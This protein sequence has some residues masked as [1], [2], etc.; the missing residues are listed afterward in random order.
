MKS[1]YLL[2]SLVAVLFVSAPS[3]AQ[4]GTQP[5]K[6]KDTQPA[7]D[8]KDDHK[9][10]DHKNDKK[11]GEKKDKSDKG[12]KVEV[13]QA[14]PDFKATDSE[15]KSV[16]L[17]D[18]QGKIVVLQWFNPNCP[19]VVKHYENGNNTFYDLNAKYKDKGVVFLAVA[20]N[21]KGEQG[22]GADAANSAR[23]NWKI[24]Y[25]IIIDESGEI[26]KAYGAKNTPGMV[27]IGKDGKIAYMG[28]IDDD[29]GPEKAGKTNYVAKALDELIAG[30]PVTT[31]T[32]QPYG[33]SVKY[34]KS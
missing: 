31:T 5:E 25:P 16:N 2:A 34:K 33:C 30:K 11:D 22:S 8:K 26:G 10:H 13:G 32:T 3:L 4:T 17:S 19:Y 15:G 20:S 28:A 23:K 18:L 9:D 7:K 29:R 14:A 1:K 24:A 6:P 21:A 12:S 27:V